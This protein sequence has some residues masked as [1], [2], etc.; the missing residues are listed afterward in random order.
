MTIDQAS[1]PLVELNEASVDY[2]RQTVLNTIDLRLHAGEKVVLLGKSG[3]GKSTVLKLLY[4]QLLKNNEP[5]AWIPQDLG[6]VLP[7]SVFHNVLMGRLDQQSRWQNLRNLLW[8]E[9]THRVAITALLAKLKL[10]A[11]LFKAAADLS[12]GQ[13]QRV[14]IARALYRQA[15]CLLADEPVANLDK[16]LAQLVLHH[17]GERYSSFVIA[18]HDTEQALSIADRIVAIKDGKIIVDQSVESL[19]PS[20]LLHIYSDDI[21]PPDKDNGDKS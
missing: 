21:P 11:G 4:Q 20:D 5:T 18:L 12:G 17:I 8:P 19:H 1:K 13:Q 15:D 16:P 3:A 14:A 9:K 7:L 6:L 2:G 10:T